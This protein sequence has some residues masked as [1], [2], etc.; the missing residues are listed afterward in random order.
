MNHATVTGTNLI[1]KYQKSYG[2]GYVRG[3]GVIESTSTQ[4]LSSNMWT[5]NLALGNYLMTSNG[6][7]MGVET[8]GVEFIIEISAV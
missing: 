8:T 3:D 7:A 4:S 2:K 5:S 6:T 1:S